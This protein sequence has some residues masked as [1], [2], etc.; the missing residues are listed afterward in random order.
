M[1]F[2]IA[3]IQKDDVL[4][5]IWENEEPGFVKFQTNDPRSML[6]LTPQTDDA[7]FGIFLH[8][9]IEAKDDSAH[10][11]NAEASMEDLLKFTESCSGIVKRLVPYV[12]VFDGSCSC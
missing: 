1:E 9:F 10:K 6:F 12:A 5:K 4:R 11:W 7:L 8:P 2:D 3:G